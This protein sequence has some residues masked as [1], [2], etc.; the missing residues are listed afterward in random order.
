MKNKP[1]LKNPSVAA[2]TVPQ[3]SSLFS[4]GYSEC[5]KRVE[6]GSKFTNSCFN[7]DWYFKADGDREELC[8][9][10]EVLKY[11]MIVTES[12]IYCNRWRLTQREQS[13]KGLFR[14]KGVKKV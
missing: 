6:K 7:C 14:K 4:R 12:G 3:K 13:V 5:R 1:R 11:D 8:Q 2:P 10:P 9:N